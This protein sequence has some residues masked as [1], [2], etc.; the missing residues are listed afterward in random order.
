ME[1]GGVFPRQRDGQ[2]AAPGELTDSATG[3]SYFIQALATEQ[4]RAFRGLVPSY[5]RTDDTGQTSQQ[6][7]NQPRRT[8]TGYFDC[9]R[10][11]IIVERFAG[12]FSQREK[13]ESNG[14][15]PPLAFPRSY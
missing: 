3:S 12:L 5:A 8:T 13:H 4:L 11:I 15:R 6:D 9:V 1:P 7:A 10:R 14:A 2:T